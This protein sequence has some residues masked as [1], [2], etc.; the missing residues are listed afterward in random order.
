MEAQGATLGSQS[1]E[2][3]SLDLPTACYRSGYNALQRPSQEAQ[4]EARSSVEP[5]SLF[6][7]SDVDPGNKLSLNQTHF[8]KTPPPSGWLFLHQ[9]GMS[10]LLPYV[11]K[12]L[13][14]AKPYRGT[15]KKA[16]GITAGVVW[17]APGT[18]GIQGDCLKSFLQGA[19]NLG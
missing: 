10:Y 14:P 7:S 15:S 1:T 12:H 3:C 18:L 9:K 16:P 2:S 4:S 19:R 17:L 13:N 5:H 11:D 6:C 8:R